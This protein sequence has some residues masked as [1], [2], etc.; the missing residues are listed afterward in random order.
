MVRRHQLQERWV[1]LARGHVTLDLQVL[2][3]REARK[4]A[5]GAVGA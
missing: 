4:T 5:K 2:S 1:I 3:H